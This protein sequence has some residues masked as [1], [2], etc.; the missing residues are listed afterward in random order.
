MKKLLTFLASALLFGCI[1]A[2]AQDFDFGLKAGITG[3]WLPNTI[4]D[5]GDKVLPNLGFYGG[6]FGDVNLSESFFV[7]AEAMYA[8]KGVSTRND[9]TSHKYSRYLSYLEV[10]VLAGFRLGY[11]DRVMFLAG[12]GFAYCFGDKVQQD[13]IFDPAST[14]NV[15]KFDLSLV[16]QASYLLTESLAV[17]F[18]VDYGFLR[19]L[20]K[21]ELTGLEDKGRNLG[22]MFGFSYAFGK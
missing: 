9:Y 12:P 20:G 8:R 19:V 2:N 15:N 5:D 18:R 7:R 3:N 6:V 10:P 14:G 11:D 17:D 13:G 16:L 1:S 21:N 4:I 22:I